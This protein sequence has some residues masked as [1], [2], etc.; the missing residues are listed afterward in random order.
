LPEANLCERCGF[1]SPEANL[2][3]RCSHGL[4]ERIFDLPERI[5]DSIKVAVTVVT[6]GAMLTVVLS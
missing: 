2:G 1:D 4:P 3:G 5:S 6:H